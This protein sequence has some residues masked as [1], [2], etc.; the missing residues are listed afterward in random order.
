MNYDGD[1]DDDGNDDGNG[2]DYKTCI[3]I[4]VVLI[5]IH[6]DDT[7]MMIYILYIQKDG[8]ICVLYSVGRNKNAY[9]PGTS[10]T[11]TNKL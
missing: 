4:I 11:C 6:N 8:D 5:M 9:W 10:A 3:I 7:R 1:N 2:K